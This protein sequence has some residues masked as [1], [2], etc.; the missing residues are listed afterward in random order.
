MA[1][2]QTSHNLLLEGP[3]ETVTPI[4]KAVLVHPIL[5]HPVGS[6]EKL[7]WPT[8]AHA[9]APRTPPAAGMDRSTTSSLFKEVKDPA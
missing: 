5:R 1:A 8:Q 9:R 6:S 2:Q 4:W 7:V 3:A